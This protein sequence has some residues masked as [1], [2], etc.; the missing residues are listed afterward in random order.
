MRFIVSQEAA[1]I[2][3]I[4][5]FTGTHGEWVFDGTAKG[6]SDKLSFKRLPSAAISSSE[7][8]E[9]E[10]GAVRSK[11]LSGK[12]SRS[13]AAGVSDDGNVE[14]SKDIQLRKGKE[15]QARRG[16]KTA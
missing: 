9:E 16:K 1:D 13:A 6:P 4:Q 10:E 15:R 3:T 2:N 5:R 12:R 7:E 8:D 14:S 11:A